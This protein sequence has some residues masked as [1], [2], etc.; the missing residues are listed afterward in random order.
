MIGCYVTTYSITEENLIPTGT[1]T[2][3][4]DKRYKINLIIILK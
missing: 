3:K 1:N 4:L 2:G